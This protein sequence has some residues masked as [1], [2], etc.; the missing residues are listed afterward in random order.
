M[1]VNEPGNLFAIAAAQIFIQKN[2]SDT[3]TAANETMYRYDIANAIV[4]PH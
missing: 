2:G 3:S 4:H 1:L